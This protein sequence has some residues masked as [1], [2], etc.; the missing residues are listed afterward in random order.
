MSENFLGLFSTATDIVLL[1]P[2]QPLFTKGER[3]SQC[4]LLDQAK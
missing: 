1:K 4:S 3:G 2:G